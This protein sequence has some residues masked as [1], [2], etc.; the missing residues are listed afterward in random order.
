MKMKI[1]F[2]VF[3][4]IFS[5]TAGPGREHIL[6]IDL[7]RRNSLRLTLAESTDTTVKATIKQGGLNKTETNHGY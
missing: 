7:Q 5:A 6:D 2:F 3:V 1:L 4:L